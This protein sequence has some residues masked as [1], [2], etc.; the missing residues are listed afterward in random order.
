[1]PNA[2]P[3]L[4]RAAARRHY[5][6]NR[7][8]YIERAKLRR[9]V[10]RWRAKR[11]AAGLRVNGDWDRR[12]KEYVNAAAK[13]GKEYWPIGCRVKVKE[14]ARH[15][16]VAQRKPWHGLGSSDAYRVRYQVDERFRQR[17]R[18]R[19]SARR[20]SNP[21]YAAQWERQ[22]DR[23]MRAM[24]SSD[25]SVDRAFVNGLMREKNC[26]YCSRY[27]PRSMREL[28]HVWP[29]SKGGTHTAD[30]LLM[31]CRQCNRSKSDALPLRWLMSV[32]SVAGP[33]ATL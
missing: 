13:R 6:Q 2:D 12:L 9:D 26:A 29:L 20:F 10:D 27:V 14:A 4:R 15:S 22:G 21:A 16:E 8:K 23:W 32:S 1:M 11:K 18:Q 5:V 33:S 7:Q 24:K 3:E 25:G 17:E 31:A 28:D 19:I 30:N